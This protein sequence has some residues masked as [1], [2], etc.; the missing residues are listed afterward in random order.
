[1]GS[2]LPNGTKDA[3]I[4]RIAGRQ[5]GIVTLAQLDA[6]GI[7]RR[8]ITRR[9]KLQRLHRIHRGVFS[10]GHTALS[11]EGRWL[12]AVLACGASAALSHVSAGALWGMLR[13]RHR[14]DIDPSQIQ[15]DRGISHVTVA[16]EGKNRGGIRVHRSRTLGRGQIT[17]RLG[18]PVATPSRTLRDLRRT[19]PQ[20]QFAAAMRQAEFLGL[21]VGGSLE[22]DRTRSELEGRFLALCRRHRLP[23]PGVNVRIG[24][25]VVDFAWPDRGVIVELD[26]YEAHRGR[27]AFEADRARDV[28]LKLLGYEV[29]RFT[30]R[31]LIGEPGQV[32]AAVRTLLSTRRE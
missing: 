14:R 24:A 6:V 8:G 22:P 15:P 13:I 30:W 17:R 10:V 32:T 2:E 1:V 16:G 7:H 4:A 19:L 9:L 12:A 3:R 26:G 5:H 28:E 11:T 27:S 20:Q 29:T 31:Q 21:P 18:I 23:R 25:F